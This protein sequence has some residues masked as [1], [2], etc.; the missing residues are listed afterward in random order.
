MAEPATKPN[1]EVIDPEANKAPVEEPIELSPEEEELAAA[2]EAAK[3]EEG[4]PPKGDEPAGTAPATEGTPDA[5]PKAEPAEAAAKKVEGEGEKGSEE[6]EPDKEVQL[7]PVSVVQAMRS[8]NNQLKQDNATLAGQ[9]YAYQTM[10]PGAKAGSED[11]PAPTP[12]ERLKQIETERLAVAKRFD[13]GELSNSEAEQ[14]KIA[15]ENEAW[16]IRQ[17][18]LAASAQPADPGPPSEDATVQQHGQKL[19]E[20]YPVL[21]ELEEEDLK[22]LVPV[23][24]KQFALEDKPLGTGPLETM[25]LRERIATIAHGMYG[26]GPDPRA[27]QP[28]TP[29]PGTGTAPTLS[30]EA[31]ARD[32]KLKAAQNHPVDVSQVGQA[33]SGTPM[34]DSEVEAK[35]AVMTDEE[36]IEF[37]DANPG[38]AKRILGP[39][40]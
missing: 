21:G 10:A 2:M 29:P 30:P 7:V 40:G 15:F 17:G 9:V 33:V 13:D 23:A 26:K 3:T 18:L 32:Q 8:E 19:Y 27:K 37:L 39:A 35:M 6:K 20:D 31:L 5:T 28:E 22:A 4:D 12:E 11:P 24:A 36:Q 16:E 38:L 14:Q 34:P 25:R 1:E